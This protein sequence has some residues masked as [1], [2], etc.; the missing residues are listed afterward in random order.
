MFRI[1][2]GT[3]AAE[4]GENGSVRCENCEERARVAIE[5]E[6]RPARGRQPVLC[7]RCGNVVIA[8]SAT[9]RYCDGACRTAAW[10][11]R[12]RIAAG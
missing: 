3:F 1:R 2:C 4:Y 9:R 10:R 11:E 6:P 12:Q 8:L 5:T 7:R